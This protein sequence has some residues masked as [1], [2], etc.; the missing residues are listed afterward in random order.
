MAQIEQAATDAGE[1][2]IA[3][4]PRLGETPAAQR[5]RRGADGLWRGVID[6]AILLEDIPVWAEPEGAFEHGRRRWGS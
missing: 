6:G 4:P 2:W 1:G 3:V 5:V